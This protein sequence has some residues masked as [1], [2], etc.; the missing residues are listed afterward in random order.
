M[1]LAEQH[2]GQLRIKITDAQS[3]GGIWRAI[4][5]GV[6]KYPTFIVDGEKYHGWNEG[7]LEAL[8]NRKLAVTS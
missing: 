5:Q 8:I 4:R 6:R 7:A 3:I 2:A 1:R